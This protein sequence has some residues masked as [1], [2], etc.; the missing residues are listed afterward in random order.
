MHQKE[1]T[2]K[3]HLRESQINEIKTNLR[4]SLV[5]SYEQET[6]AKETNSSIATAIQ[7]QDL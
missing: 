7:K 3:K 2:I 5:L 4:A 1:I 6:K